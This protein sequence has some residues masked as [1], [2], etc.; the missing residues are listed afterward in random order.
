MC[1]EPAPTRTNA[2]PGKQ[3]LPVLPAETASFTEEVAPEFQFRPASLKGWSGTR[4][5]KD[6]PPE[7]TPPPAE[8]PSDDADEIIARL[9]GRK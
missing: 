1:H 5:V 3:A 9:F 7:P 2:L 4:I 8:P 6:K